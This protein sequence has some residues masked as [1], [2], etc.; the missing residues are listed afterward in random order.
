MAI[1]VPCGLVPE[2]LSS[3]SPRSS[4]PTTGITQHFCA[5]V[6]TKLGDADG[7]PLLLTGNG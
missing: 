7:Q 3:L 1:R 5:Q 2:C 6:D 4:L